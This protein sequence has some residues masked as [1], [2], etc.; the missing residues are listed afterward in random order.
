VNGLVARDTENDI[1]LNGNFYRCHRY[2]SLKKQTATLEHVDTLKTQS[3]YHEEKKAYWLS[4]S[5]ICRQGNDVS[6]NGLQERI[7][8]FLYYY[9]KWG[10]DFIQQFYQH[11]LALEEEFVILS[12]P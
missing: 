3:L 4:A 6:K 10:K 5:I 9:A 12:E 2:E 1:K 8:N 7:D 11:S